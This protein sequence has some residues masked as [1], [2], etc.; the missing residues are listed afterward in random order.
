MNDDRHPAGHPTGDSV[1]PAG[2]TGDDEAVSPLD[3]A[4]SA[5]LDARLHRDQVADGTAVAAAQGA[6][7]G[8]Q[9]SPVTSP[10]DAG[11]RA[12]DMAAAREALRDRSDSLPA[13]RLAGMLLDAVARAGV[14]DPSAAVGRSSEPAGG[15]SATVTSLA[16]ARRRPR[17]RRGLVVAGAAA[18][19]VAVLGIG[20]IAV[21]S[22]GGGGDDSAAQQ[23]AESAADLARGAGS[24][25]P[26]PAQPE[27]GAA[28]AP[29]TMVTL[30]SG[31][32][33]KASAPDDGSAAP[34]AASA[35]PPDVA[36]SA[37]VESKLPGTARP[38]RGWLARLLDTI[39]AAAGAGGTSTTTT[40]AAPGP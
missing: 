22:G 23:S 38:V 35:G 26:A 6:V 12:D 7:G 20:S 27:S 33:A 34:G 39:A 31:A 1:A 40:T 25:S 24:D 3:E 18:A 11:R 9:A 28:A 36:Q 14:D 15:R 5:L 4:A 2:A 13:D 10:G 8:Q 17:E 32:G 16:S 30:P 29:T 21:V 19:A 37:P